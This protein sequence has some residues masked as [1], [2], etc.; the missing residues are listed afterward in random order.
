MSY[1]AKIMLVEDS[2]N[3]RLVLK[4]Y[5]EMM[6]YEVI[7]F[8]NGKTASQHFRKNIFDLCI[9]DVM[10][11]E[12]DGFELAEHIRTI[13]V[14]IPIIFLTA[15][16]SKEDKI[17]GFKLGCD[18]YIT[19]PFNTEELNLRLEAIL[20]RSKQGNLNPLQKH[21]DLKYQLAD[22]VF[23]FGNLE[24]ITPKAKINLTKKEARLLQLLCEN[25]NK[26]LPREII[27]REIW[28]E[29]DRAASRSMDVFIA[30]LRAY[31]DPENVRKRRSSQ[32]DSASDLTKVEIENAH[33]S[34]F[35][36]RVRENGM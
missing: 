14:Q 27:L 30:K 6:D 11:P 26:L 31:L 16:I 34:G 20:R 28:G 18:D 4:D 12:K 22:I 25:K 35:V 33:G 2:Q 17:R 8:E 32:K 3:L 21:T 19:K 5:L 36:L 24:L 7:E 23:D 9:L 29:D 10:M 13:D 1:K 15:K